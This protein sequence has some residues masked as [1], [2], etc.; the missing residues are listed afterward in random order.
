MQ[1]E[2]Q[3]ISPTPS[4]DLFLDAG[5]EGIV[6]II[7]KEFKA[8]NV[9]YI[10][11]YG[12]NRRGEVKHIKITKTIYPLKNYANNIKK[13]IE[14]SEGKVEPFRIEIYMVRNEWNGTGRDDIM[15]LEFNDYGAESPPFLHIDVLESIKSIRQ[16]KR[17]IKYTLTYIKLIC[18]MTVESFME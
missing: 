11:E 7:E 3:S 18:A 4:P 12:V 16:L 2:S 8:K 10:F 17:Y 5:E 14:I 13:I 6:K 15:V 1:F 9:E